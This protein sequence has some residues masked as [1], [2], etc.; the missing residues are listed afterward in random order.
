[1]ICGDWRKKVKKKIQEKEDVEDSKTETDSDDADI[2]NNL[3]NEKEKKQKNEQKNETQKEKIASFYTKRFSKKNNIDSALKEDVVSLSGITDGFSTEQ[4]SSKRVRGKRYLR[5][6]GTKL[7][8]YWL[9]RNRYFFSNQYNNL[10]EVFPKIELLNLYKL[11]EY[12]YFVLINDRDLYETAE[13]SFIVSTLRERFGSAIV[14]DLLSTIDHKQAKKV[15]VIM[16]ISDQLPKVQV[17]DQGF[18]TAVLEE[19]YMLKESLT[20][21]LRGSKFNSRVFL[22]Q[23]MQIF[24]YHLLIYYKH[25]G[26]KPKIVNQKS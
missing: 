19:S 22:S 20:L 9:A 13:Y 24:L 4:F 3:A 10:F 18:E 1:M 2:T 21:D 16:H 8:A 26:N 6:R 12:F 14:N 23:D 11:V 17:N 5:R 15:S 7:R 25:L